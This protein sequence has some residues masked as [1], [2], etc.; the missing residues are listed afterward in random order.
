MFCAVTFDIEKSHPDVLSSSP[1]PSAFTGEKPKGFY[2]TRLGPLWDYPC[3]PL[4]RGRYFRVGDDGNCTLVNCNGILPPGSTVRVKYI[5]TDPK[6]A[7]LVLESK[8]SNPIAL[9]TPVPNSIID[10]GLKEH[11]AEMV[12][13]TVV[14]SWLMAA[15]LLLLV[16]LLIVDRS[17]VI[18]RKNIPVMLKTY[19]NFFGQ[20]ISENHL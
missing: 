19:K 10:D 20:A 4:F 8:W 7:G 3:S 9:I 12:V 16:G 2:I 13:I 5:L 6:T 1:Y 11:S 18:R 15:L 14:T 17:G